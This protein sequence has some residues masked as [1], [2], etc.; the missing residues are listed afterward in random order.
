VPLFDKK[1]KGETIINQFKACS[2]NIS[3]HTVK[4]IKERYGEKYCGGKKIKN[5]SVGRVRTII[6]NQVKHHLVKKKKANITS[7]YVETTLFSFIVVRGYRNEIVT[8]LPGENHYNGDSGLSCTL[9]ESSEV[10]RQLR[11]AM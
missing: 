5:M 3:R 6:L 11:K 7:F 10:L 8:A 9:G 1:L 4:R 2:F